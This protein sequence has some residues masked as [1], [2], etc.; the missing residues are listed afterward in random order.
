MFSVRKSNKHIY[1]EKVV[2]NISY[3]NLYI[4]KNFLKSQWQCEQD[5]T[6]YRRI[7]GMFMTE[8]CVKV[9]YW[10]T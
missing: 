3:S 7:G 1:Q 6:A 5:D 4:M 8:K 2:F 10:K 9:V